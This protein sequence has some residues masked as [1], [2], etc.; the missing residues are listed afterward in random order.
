MLKTRNRLVNFRLTQ[1]EYDKIQTALVARG[2]RCF[3]DFARNAVMH[4]AESDDP[5]PSSVRFQFTHLDRRIT[6]LESSLREIER[7]LNKEPSEA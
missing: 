6:H 2:L 1:E 5:L 7:Q 3:S 4:Y